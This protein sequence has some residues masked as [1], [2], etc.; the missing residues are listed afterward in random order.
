MASL[1]N[2]HARA[3]PVYRRGVSLPQDLPAPQSPSQ[4]APDDPGR[5]PAWRNLPRRSRGLSL[6]TLVILRWMAIFGQS[7]TIGTATLYFHFDLPLWGCL[8]AIAA[9]V[10][11]NLNATSRLKRSDGS[12]PDGRLTAAHLGFDILQLS[13]LLGLTGGLQNPFCLLLVAPVTVAAASLPGRQAALMGLLVLAATVSLFFVSLPLPWT[14]GTELNLPPLYK[15][16]IGLALVTGVI[17]TS[18]YAWRVA[19]DAEK[20]ELALATTQDVLQR[21]Q[22]LAALGGLAAAAAHELGTPLAT[23]QVVAR[24]LLRASAKDGAAAEDAAL[25]LQ[26]AERCRDILKRL[27]QQPEE[28]EAAFAEVGLKALLEEVVEP[29]R[30]F[31]LDFEVSVRTASGESAPRV[32]RLP[33]VIHGLSTLVENAADFAAAKVRVRAVVDAGFIE[34]EVVDDG[35]G[36]PADILPRLGEPYVTSRPQGKARR[37]LSA[38]IAASVAAATPGRKGKKATKVEPALEAIAPSQGG[39]GLGFFIART[40]LERTGGKVFVGPGDGGQA[41]VK[42][43]TPAK[44]LPKGARVAVRWP[45]PALEVSS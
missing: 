22:R 45:R 1:E 7:A 32:R 18:A 27:S 34:I 38:Q 10:A 43:Q 4:F 30:G 33:E 9:S 12:L 41:P 35:P 8:A 39:M 25:I 29:H 13:I 15:F 40:L 31:D 2:A 44:G 28:G 26:Q 19:A 3:R 17:F 37:A 24:E 14:A 6:R 42:G 21:E 20:L 23:I 5:F 16:G 11:M 36:F